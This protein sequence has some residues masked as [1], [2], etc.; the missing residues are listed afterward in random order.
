M[1]CGRFGYGC[2]SFGPSEKQANGLLSEMQYSS[3][4]IFILP[5]I[6]PFNLFS[7]W[8][9]GIRNIDTIIY[10]RAKTTAHEFLSHRSGSFSYFEMLQFL[11]YTLNFIHILIY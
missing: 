9:I 3:N 10:L 7:F 11:G 5:E 1:T 4:D 6:L 2:H 8:I